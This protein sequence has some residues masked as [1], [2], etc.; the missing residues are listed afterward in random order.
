MDTSTSQAMP[1]AALAP[2]IEIKNMEASKLEVRNPKF[3]QLYE[4]HTNGINCDLDT[5]DIVQR[6]E[7]WDALYSIEIS[8]VEN[9]SLLVTFAILPDEL[10]EFANEIYEFCPDIIDQHFGCMDDIVGMTR[11]ED[12]PPELAEILEGINFEDENFGLI[13]LR[14]SLERT[15]QLSLWWD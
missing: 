1:L 3:Q 14:R 15:K 10:D 4:K 2:K 12:L 7:Q 13:L 11:T 8:E 6:L 9:D 5:D